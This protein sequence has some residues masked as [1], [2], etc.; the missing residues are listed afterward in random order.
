MLEKMWKNWNPMHCRQNRK[1]QTAQ[2][3]WKKYMMSSLKPNTI[4]K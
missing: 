3:T 2:D 4:I 1:W